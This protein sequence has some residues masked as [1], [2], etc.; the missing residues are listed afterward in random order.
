M[1]FLPLKF[2]E[3][4]CPGGEISRQTTVTKEKIFQLR[5]ILTFFP[6]KTSPLK[7]MFEEISSLFIF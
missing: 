7:R 1:K 4:Y 6:Q 2:D 5:S 3:I